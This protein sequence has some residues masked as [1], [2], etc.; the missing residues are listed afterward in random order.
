MTGQELLARG[1][2]AARSWW[3]LPLLLML[4]AMV[5]A[6]RL[7]AGR[8]AAVTAR[9]LAEEAQ[10][11]AEGFLVV[12]QAKTRDLEREAR[13]LA[14]ENLDLAAELARAR[15]AAPGARV[16][17][18]VSASTGPRTA[19][20]A[21]RPGPACPPPEG[22]P[23]AQIIPRIIPAPPA[24]VLAAGDTGEIRVDQVA[25]ETR[26]GAQLLVGAASVWRL[27]PAPQTKLLSG[28]FQATLSTA[29]K[30]APPQTLRWGGGL[31]L[32]LS[33]EGWAIGPAVALPPARL[34]GMQGEV[35]L[36]WGVGPN[37]A[38]QGGGAALVRW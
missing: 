9:R 7:Q 27:D 20:G 6:W 3:A 28:G 17:G 32:G 33:R 38:W 29:K 10:L 35:V 4:V 11:R 26:E 30:E 1:R 31:Y 21:P 14:G 34:L 13:R 23:P 19:G 25:L 16:V 36:G 18:T 22:P 15:A 8:E 5:L 24:C 2:A 37:G 12:E